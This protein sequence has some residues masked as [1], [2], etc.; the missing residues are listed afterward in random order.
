MNTT[1]IG[2]GV[3]YV[4]CLVVLLGLDAIWLTS[5]RQVLYEPAIGSLLAD[6]PNFAAIVVFYLLYPMGVVFFAIAPADAWT[7]ALLRGALFGLFAYATYDLTNQATLRLWSTRLTVLD[8]IW[9]GGLTAIAALAGY[10]AAR[11]IG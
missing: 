11:R 5:M 9:G 8:M 1:P 7:Q 10:A 4:A 6:K 3:S 2:F